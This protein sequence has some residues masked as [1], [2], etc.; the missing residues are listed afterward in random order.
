M[1][2][3]LFYLLLFTAALLTACS[4]RV[5]TNELSGVDFSTYET[6]AYL[7]SGDS[8]EY[9][10]ILEKK[11]V[12]EVRQEMEARGYELNSQDPDLLI[13]VKTMFEE[14]ERLERDPV[15]TTYDYYAPG[16][17]AAGAQDPIYYPNYNAIPRITPYDGA[18]QEIEYTEGTF[19]VDVI[20]ASTNQII[21]RGWSETPVDRAF[22]DESIRNYIDNIYEEYPVEPVNN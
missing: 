4:A 15:F 17:Y 5:N 13:L 10:T 8:S 11:V 21:W 18:I 6:F 20:D 7:P 22:L 19:V 2:R 9:R 14:E 1:T 12:K 16:F 3:H